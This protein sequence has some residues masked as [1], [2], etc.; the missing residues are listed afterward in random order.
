MGDPKNS[1]IISNRKNQRDTRR[2]N[3]L[4]VYHGKMNCTE[5]LSSPWDGQQNSVKYLDSLMAIDFSYTAARKEVREMKPIMVRD[6]S[7]DR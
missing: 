6:R 3:T 5:I 4:S 7:L 2:R 1:M